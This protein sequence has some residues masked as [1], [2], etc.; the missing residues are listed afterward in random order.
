MGQDILVYGG[1][2]I[3]NYHPVNLSGS[4]GNSGSYVFKGLNG[5]RLF[6]KFKEMIGAGEGVKLEPLEDSNLIKNLTQEV[7][8]M[9]SE[10]SF[11]Y[12]AYY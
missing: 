1:D 4:N 9:E 3:Y 10:E 11:P 2:Y 8:R 6:Y 7:E 5:E 12:T